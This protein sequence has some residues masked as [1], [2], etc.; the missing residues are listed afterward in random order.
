MDPDILAL[1][2]PI[3]AIVGGCSI[4]IT[5]IIL[6]AKN[7]GLSESQMKQ[8]HSRLTELNDENKSLKNRVLN[9]EAITS[10]FDNQLQLEPANKQL[11]Q[12]IEEIIEKKTTERKK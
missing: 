1:L 10:D 6:N 4:A 11:E 2:I 7:K 12:K 9:L 3:V 8:L 5:K